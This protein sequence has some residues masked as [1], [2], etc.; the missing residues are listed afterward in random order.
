M[1]DSKQKEGYWDFYF[2]IL[3]VLPALLGRDFSFLNPAVY[4][5]RTFIV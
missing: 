1:V 3:T 5:R 4:Y 2:L